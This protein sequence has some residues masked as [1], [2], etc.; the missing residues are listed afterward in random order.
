[1]RT[2]QSSLPAYSAEVITALCLLVPALLDSPRL[3][4]AD[5][6]APL[7][8]FVA[9]NGNDQWSGGSIAPNAAGTDGPLASVT[10]A[11]DAIR[12]RRAA[13][14]RGGRSRFTYEAAL[15]G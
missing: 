8:L 4:A 5:L 15:I 12:R 1:M 7:T 3:V 10:A 2:P 14:R 11:R 9:T 6:G 13:G